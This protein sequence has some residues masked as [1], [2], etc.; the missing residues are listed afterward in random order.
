VKKLVLVLVVALVLCLSVF[1]LTGCGTDSD[2][3][4]TTTGDDGTA[5]G[6]GDSFTFAQGADP[7]G[8][9]PAY[10]DDG[11]S[12]KVMGNIYEGLTRYADDS[13]EVIPSLAESWD[14]SDD[15]LTYTFHLREGVK[16]SDGTDFNADAVKF[17]IDRQ[18]DYDDRTWESEPYVD[19]PYASFVF[20][21]VKE[22]KV[23][24]DYTVEIDLTQTNAA[25]LANMAMTMAAPIVSPTAMDNDPTSTALMENPVGTGPYKFVKWNKEENVQLVRND[26]YWGTPALTENVIFRIIADN[27]ARVLALNNDEIDMADGIDATLVDQIKNG[28]S[29]LYEAAGM[30]VN[31]MAY[32]TQS[33][34]F[35]NQ[36]ARIAISQAINVPELVES[37]YQGFATPA[38]TILPTFVPGF[39]PDVRQISYNPEEAQET[40]DRLGIKEIHMIAYSNPRPYNPATGE[41]LAVAIAGYLEKMGITTVIDKYDWTTYKEKVTTED[42]DICFYGWTGD[43]GDPDNFMNLLS[44]EDLAMNV[45]RFRDPVYNQMIKDALAM[46]NGPE[47]EAAYAEMEKYVAEHAI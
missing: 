3:G 46:P 2:D 10:V 13:T 7:R 9:D 8:L 11:E 23:I 37:L 24:D 4:T 42:Y 14:V 28:G 47:R 32:N 16:F 19:M 17:S 25:F 21:T 34:I 5:V 41:T 36:D 43:N 27:A 29:N 44:D 18:V 12:A 1:A 33:E 20:D 35:K 15:G 6:A 38:D 22:V 45:A 39:S 26:D 30:N 31:Y 40:I